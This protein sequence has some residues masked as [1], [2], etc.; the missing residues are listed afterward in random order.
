M[1]PSDEHVAPEPVQRPPWQFPEQH[2]PLEVH[3]LP[4]VVQPPTTSAAHL[5]ETQ[6]LLQHS[7]SLAQA[8][9]SDLQT[10]APHLLFTQVPLQQSVEIEHEPPAVVHT[11]WLIA[12]VFETVSHEPEQQPV[13]A[14]HA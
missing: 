8:C 6:L 10:A 11:P 2:A 12:H 7:P 14:T 5:F 4:S 1:S 9:V 13:F 3:A